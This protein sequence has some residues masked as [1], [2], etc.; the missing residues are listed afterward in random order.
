M[1]SRLAAL[2][3]KKPVVWLDAD[4]DAGRPLGP[5]ATA[6]WLDSGARPAWKRNARGLP[7][8]AVVGLAVQSVIAASL[9][10]HSVPRKAMGENARSLFPRKVLPTAERLR[11]LVTELP[12]GLRASF[13]DTLLA[14]ASMSRQRHGGLHRTFTL[15]LEHPI[16][17][18]AAFT[19]VDPTPVVN[20][21]RC[22]PPGP[23]T[24]CVY[25]HALP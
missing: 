10:K 17:G 24:Q 22:G 18:A 7:E 1:P 21:H 8:S 16:P 6:P 2:D 9:A 13:P 4:A 11:S 3:G 20:Q 23:S 15:T 5:G 25:T 12:E 14:I 19:T